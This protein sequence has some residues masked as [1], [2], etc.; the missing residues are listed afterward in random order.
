M[1][2]LFRDGEIETLD[3]GQFLGHADG[4]GGTPGLA[5]AGQSLEMVHG[6]RLQIDDGLIEEGELS[7]THDAAET[8]GVLE[9][10]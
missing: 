6:P 8:V 5:E 4:R 7:I 2:D 3:Q 9:G 10:A 1:D